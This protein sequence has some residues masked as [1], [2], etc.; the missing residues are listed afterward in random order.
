[1]Q[2]KHLRVSILSVLAA[3]LLMCGAVRIYTLN[4]AYPSAA[5]LKGN[6][7]TPIRWNGLA[8]QL[9]A[10]ELVGRDAMHERY[11]LDPSG[12]FSD[13]NAERFSVFC[14]SVTK[15]EDTPEQHQYDLDMVGAESGAWKNLMAAGVYKALNPEAKPIAAMEVGETQKLIFAVGLHQDAFRA[16]RWDAL[17]ISDFDLVLAAYPDKVILR[18]E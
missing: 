2:I 15:Q 10:G 11:G 8:F 9:T 13:S 16:D 4:K 14:V 3:A 6:M 17:E 5:V 18:C 7:E 1:M 12:A